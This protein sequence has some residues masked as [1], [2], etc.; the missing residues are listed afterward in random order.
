MSSV[1]PEKSRQAL[2]HSDRVD[3]CCLIAIVFAA[4]SVLLLMPLS[5]FW[6]RAV[7]AGLFIESTLVH[8]VRRE[9]K[10]RRHFLARAKANVPIQPTLSVEWHISSRSARR[11]ARG[12]GICLITRHSSAR[13]SLNCNM[14][15]RTRNSVLPVGSS[16]PPNAHGPIYLEGSE[17]GDGLPRTRQQAQQQTGWNAQRP[18][19][20]MSRS[21]P[22]N[23]PGLNMT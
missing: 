15:R 6:R 20:H 4:A 19:A 11:A 17:R 12:G 2:S 23:R 18:L 1:L 5:T 13:L 9:S 10:S 7:T 3:L 16:R 8:A 22:T 21:V 14:R